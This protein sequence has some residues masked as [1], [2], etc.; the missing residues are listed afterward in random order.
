MSPS[1][2][3]ANM[4]Q[5]RTAT[6]GPKEALSRSVPRTRPDPHYGPSHVMDDMSNAHFTLAAG[7][8]E[9]YRRHIDPSWV[10]HNDYSGGVGA[11][12][13]NVS[14][15]AC[16]DSYP[17]NTMCVMPPTI[18]TSGLGDYDMLAQS[19]IHGNNTISGNYAQMSY[20][21]GPMDSGL[22]NDI[23]MGS[24]FGMY[25]TPI[26]VQPTVPMETGWTNG[27]PTP[28]AEEYLDSLL[29]QDCE[30]SYTDDVL[31]GSLNAFAEPETVCEFVGVSKVQPY[32]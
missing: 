3:R 1:Q 4:S 10:S 29:S 23:P 30:M 28:P 22:I 20:G 32:R 25:D 24:N 13:Q 26:D 2:R 15:S 21:D 31:A 7:H 17:V 5:T 6:K 12:Y 18:M 11:Q 8:P 19:A 16:R 27:C 9:F 14:A